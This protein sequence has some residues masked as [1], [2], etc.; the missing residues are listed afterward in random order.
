MVGDRRAQAGAVA[1][2]L[3]AQRAAGRSV[4]VWLGDGTRRSLRVVA[5]LATGT[6]SNGVHVTGRNAG[7]A[8]TDHLELSWRPGTDTAAAE[9]AVRAA[10]APSGARVRTGDDWIADQRPTGSRQT[11]AGYLVVLGIALIYTGIAVA[12]TM[13]MATSDRVGETAV[14]RLVGATRRQV[15]LFVVAET[16][17]VVAAG[18]ILGLLVTLLNLLGLWAALAALSA[19]AVVVVPWP[20]LAGT[21]LACAVIAALT[22]GATTVSALRRRPRTGRRPACGGT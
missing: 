1:G 17:A 9:A 11:L 6:G 15:V 5:V 3:D 2:H 7:G 10:L 22:A 12:T 13:V 16:L 21:S 18:A 20:V 4:E 19:P 14:L 8:P